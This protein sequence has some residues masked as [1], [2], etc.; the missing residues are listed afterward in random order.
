MKILSTLIL[1]LLFIT[2]NAQSISGKAYY[3]SKTSV[4]SEEIGRKDM[5]EN[6]RKMIAD[7][8]KNFLE[9]S[10][11]LT[12]TTSE[13]LYEEEE[14]VDLNEGQNRMAMMM[15]SFV[16]GKQYKNLDSK[17]YVEE[18]EFFGKQFLI[19]DSLPVLEWNLEKESKQIG[20]YTVFKATAIHKIPES[21]I[22]NFR[23]RPSDSLS[24]KESFIDVVVTAWYTP[25]IPVKNGPAQFHGLPG[26][27]LELNYYRTTILCSKIVLQTQKEETIKPLTKGKE[28]SRDEFQEI[29]VEK[30]QEMRENFR[31]G[32]VRDGMQ[33]RGRNE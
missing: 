21:E 4:N 27:I 3:M 2:S 13:S 1:C 30:T 16:P 9:K 29:V 17:A 31:N 6:R 12:F 20:Q 5:D 7:R 32:R 33:G 8:M 22:T 15:G 25:M 18:R 28:V 23:R 19:Q 10:Y 24:N 26:L 11:V 14:Q